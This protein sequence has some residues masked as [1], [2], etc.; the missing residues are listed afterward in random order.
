MQKI[1]LRKERERERKKERNYCISERV[2]RIRNEHRW[3]D[4]REKDGTDGSIR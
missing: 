3:K 1:F 4:I 2:L